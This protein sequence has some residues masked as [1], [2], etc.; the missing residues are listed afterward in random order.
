M[1][2]W[3]CNVR[4]SSRFLM[5]AL[6]SEVFFALLEDY[7]SRHTPRQYAGS[8]AE[9]FYADLATRQ[10]RLPWLAR[11]LEFERAAMMTSMD[12]QPRVVR[13]FADPLP[14][15]NALTEG[16]LPDIVPREGEYEIELTPDGPFAISPGAGQH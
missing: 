12:G 13:F 15:L 5:L 14:M 7:W 1:P 9:G 8:E 10:L 3:P 6:T 11:L 2:P 16:R 4:S